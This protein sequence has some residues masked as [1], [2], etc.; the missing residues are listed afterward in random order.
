[1][2]R[3]AKERSSTNVNFILYSNSFSCTFCKSYLL[4]LRVFNFLSCTFCS[5]KF[6]EQAPR[7]IQFALNSTQTKIRRKTEK[8]GEKIPHGTWTFFQIE[9][10]LWNYVQCFQCILRYTCVTL[11]RC[12]VNCHYISAK[13]ARSML[14]L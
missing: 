5:F 10:L 9:A 11:K 6:A 3:L 1:M 13:L 14:K 12:C 7:L 2:E 4:M 8:K